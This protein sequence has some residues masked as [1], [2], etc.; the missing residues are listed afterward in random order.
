MKKN[1]V[2]MVMLVLLVLM[3]I[4]PAG[5][6]EANLSGNSQILHDAVRWNLNLPKQSQVVRAEE[7]LFKMTKEITL[8]TLLVEVAVTPELEMQYGFGSKI[9][10][11][12]LDTGLIIDYKNFDGDVRWPDEGE[13]IAKE[14]A[15]NLLYNGY[16]AWL[17]GYN[18]C[19]MSMHEFITPF[20]EEEI[21]AINASLTE[22]FIR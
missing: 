10:V 18:E 22:I 15:L 13:V 9:L 1:C 8:H 16:W 3:A 20:A 19:I 12:D 5:L 7:Y 17:E 6:A 2:L 14:D 21:A 4:A 11:V